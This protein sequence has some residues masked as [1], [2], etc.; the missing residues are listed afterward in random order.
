MH[1]LLLDYWI[2]CLTTPWIG[3][4]I[5]FATGPSQPLFHISGCYDLGLNTLTESPLQS[6]WV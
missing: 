6:L 2:A 3:K 4:N 5:S 1:S